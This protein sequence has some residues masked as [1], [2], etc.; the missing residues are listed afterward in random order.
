MLIAGGAA[1]RH[2]LNIRFTFDA[3]RP[4][5]GAAL[6]CTVALLAL[7]SRSGSREQPA[8]VA[9]SG[10]VDVADVRHVI[11]RRCTVCHAGQPSDLTFGPAPGGVRFDTPAEIERYATRIRERAVITRTMPPGNKTHMTDAERDLLARWTAR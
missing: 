9:T 6:A 3:W 8:L 5:L 7:L 1:V 2:V 11:D 4:A 10:P